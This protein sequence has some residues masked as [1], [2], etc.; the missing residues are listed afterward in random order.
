MWQTENELN[1]AWLAAFSGQRREDIS[2]AWRKWSFLT[3]LLSTLRAAVKDED[4]NGMTTMNFHTDIPKIAHDALF[5]KGFY[6]DA[7]EDWYS[8]MDLI[9]FDAFVV[10]LLFLFLILLSL[11]FSVLK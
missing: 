8:M 7:V 1:E 6:L 11:L 3:T 5:L 10:F 4:P 9:S 2:G